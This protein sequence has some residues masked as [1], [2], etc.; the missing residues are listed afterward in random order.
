[1]QKFELDVFLKSESQVIF[2]NF[3]ASFSPSISQVYEVHGSAKYKELNQSETVDVESNSHDT[4]LAV[5]NGEIEWMGGTYQGEL[6]NGIPQG[7]GTLTRHG[8]VLYVGNFEIGKFHGLGTVRHVD[9]TT[10]QC[11][12][13]HGESST[14]K[15]TSC[16]VYVY[17]TVATVV[18]FGIWMCNTIYDV[19][20]KS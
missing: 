4:T 19:K 7:H 2:K 13:S 9:G 14:I 6:K 3:A 11:L 10:T 18:I 5:I 15:S 12:W 8:I 1:M 16:V 17:L 20:Q